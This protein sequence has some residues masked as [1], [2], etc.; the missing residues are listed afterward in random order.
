MAVKRIVDTGFW[1]DNK[2]VDLFSPEDKYFMLYLL[3]NPHTTQLGI[4]QFNRRV[5]AFEMGYSLEAVT[6]LL[7]RFETKYG[8]IKISQETNE[9]AIKNFLK[10]SII[11]GGA[12]VRDCL[13]KEIKATK[14]KELVAFV[15]SYIKD[16]DD[17][18]ETVKNLIA[19]Y[20]KENGDVRYVHDTSTIRQRSRRDTA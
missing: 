17:L 8:I 2:V 16:I 3:T 18:N 9:L 11:K 6:V 13:V 7:D 15:F 5:M 1:N 19:E 10:Y 4:Y 12:P 20:E 14:N